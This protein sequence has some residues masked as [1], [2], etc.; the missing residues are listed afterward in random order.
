MIMHRLTLV[1]RTLK[2]LKLGLEILPHPPYN[3]NLAPSDYRLFSEMKRPLRGKR[4]SDF[5]HLK[6]TVD[7]WIQGTPEKFFSTGINKL[8]EE[9]NKCISVAGEYIENYEH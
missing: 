1:M 3:P 8:P 7:T 9:W 6:S 4:F 2:I 5:G